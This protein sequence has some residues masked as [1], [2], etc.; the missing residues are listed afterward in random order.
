MNV[1]ETWQ[2]PDWFAPAAAELVSA[3]RPAPGTAGLRII[4]V[5]GTSADEPQLL[6]AARAAGFDCRCEHWSEGAAGS[7]ALLFEAGDDLAGAARCLRAL[8]AQ[9]QLAALPVAALPALLAVQPGQ[10]SKLDVALGFDD[11]VLQ[12]CLPLEVRA[13]ARAVS[14]RRR[15]LAAPLHDEALDDD[16][17]QVDAVAHE[18]LVDGQIIRMTAREFA[19]FAYLRA[20]PERVLTRQHL[21]ERVWGYRYRGGPRTVDTHIGR[22]RLKFGASFPIETVRSNGYRL[23]AAGARASQHV[24]C[25]VPV[26]ELAAQDSSSHAAE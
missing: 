17:L 4:I 22:L 23:R 10:L 25:Q 5:D 3:Q 15:P 1:A 24:P 12:P 8:R 20:R 18:A 21:L 6:A 19:L 14:Q 13:R 7:A 26:Q 11:F 2:P 9:A 16:G